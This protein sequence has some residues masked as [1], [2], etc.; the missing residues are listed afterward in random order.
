MI[1]DLLLAVVFSL[2]SCMLLASAGKETRDVPCWI[3]LSLIFGICNVLI[4][5]LSCLENKAQPNPFS[6]FT[7]GSR[8]MFLI[9]CFQS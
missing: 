5:L 3:D 6:D 8:A 9:N 1:M 2:S 4:I 7:V